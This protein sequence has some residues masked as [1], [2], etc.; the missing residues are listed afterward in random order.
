MGGVVLVEGETV[1]DESCEE[2]ALAK[3]QEARQAFEN[4]KSEI[5]V[6]INSE[7]DGVTLPRGTGRDLMD[8]FNR[9]D[10]AA[11]RWVSAEIADLVQRPDAGSHVA[12]IQRVLEEQGFW[13]VWP[14]VN[15][16]PYVETSS[17]LDRANAGLASI[18]STLAHE[19]MS[20]RM[21]AVWDVLEG[22]G[23]TRPVPTPRIDRPAPS[24]ASSLDDELNRIVRVVA[25]AAVKDAQKWYQH[26]V[27]GMDGKIKRLHGK[28][29]DV[30]Q[31]EA[32][33]SDVK[34]STAMLL[35]AERG[36]AKAPPE[37]VVTRG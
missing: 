19:P 7:Q 22:H 26:A 9:L 4:L 29:R 18:A 3:A 25:I 35:E 31:V 8:A 5:L 36:L 37:S 14:A 32:W 12:E 2:S 10:A 13:R 27:V 21:L 17:E 11:E 23:H 34:R 6:V 20:E 33:W 30:A 1:M 16:G 24:S 28:R 15:H